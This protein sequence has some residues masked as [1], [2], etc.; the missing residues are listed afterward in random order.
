[1]HQFLSGRHA[2]LLIP[3]FS[4]PSTASW[5][6]GEI[7]DLARAAR[8]VRSAGL[9][10]ML[11]LPVSEMADGQTSPYSA[12][13]AMAIDPI[14]ISLPAVDD[15]TALGGEDAAEPAF[16]AGVDQAR[17]SAA[18]DYRLVRRLKT[19]ALGAA[20]ARFGC[21]E[22]ARDTP[23]ARALR[24]FIEAQAWW[25]DDHA[26]FRALHARFEGRSW[27][28]WPDGL[29][30]REPGALAQARTELG[31]AI[32]FHQYLQW[33]ADGQWQAARAGLDGVGLFGD[34]PFMVSLDSADVWSRQDEFLFDRSVGVPP[35][36]FSETGQD[37]R[38]PVYRWDLLAARDYDWLRDRARRAA[39]LYDGYRVDHVVGFFRTYV[40][41][42]D[43]SPAY[44]MPA[45]VAEQ[46]AQGE[47]LLTIFASYGPRVI[48]EDLGTVPDFVRASLADLGLP[49]YRVL[50]WERH[51]HRPG[52]PFRD[53]LEYP[54]ASV[55]TSGTHDTETLAAWWD[56]APAEERAAV[57]AIPTLARG[58]LAEHD[59]CTPDVRDALVDLLLR[60]G[61][62]LA[63][64]PVQDLFGWHARINIPGIVN[65][66]NWTWRLPWPVDRM[67][68][69]ACP[70]ARAA[71]IRDMAVA[72]RRR[73][74]DP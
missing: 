52:R 58:D 35:D 20:F 66:E 12:L 18:I 60:S 23:R 21:E 7:P 51:W 44:F 22:W 63:V 62:D 74:L 50:R 47:R 37:W 14:F 4:M 15:F 31:R 43:G 16:R 65:G 36:A 67:D 39:S 10:F 45:S 40:R 27:V 55:A 68:E 56:G 32:L 73:T 13:S 19:E 54:A 70:R 17:R 64:L 24:T 48:A 30:E 53:P 25:L 28:E 3:L 69:E 6:I 72:A 29:R 5:G 61:S 34:F 46:R 57:A 49:G 42:H 41:P 38:L 33:L 8:W 26:L 2:G 11:L 9:D 59:T 1:M 71:V